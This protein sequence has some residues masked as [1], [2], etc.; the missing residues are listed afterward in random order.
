VYKVLIHKRVIKSLEKITDKE[1]KKRLKE[2]IYHL[3]DYPIILG[4]LDVEKLEGLE[5]VFRVRIGDYRII[6]YVDKKEHTIYVTHIG[7]RKTIYKI[8]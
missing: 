4:N 2:A 7:H 8:K 6:F 5:R 1:S 3:S